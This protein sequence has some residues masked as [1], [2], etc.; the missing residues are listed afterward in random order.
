MALN[1]SNTACSLISTTLVKW[2]K[3]IGPNGI[4]KLLQATIATAACKNQLTPVSL[5]RVNVD[6]RYRARSEALKL[7][8]DI[9]D[10]MQLNLLNY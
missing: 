10:L 2:R 5:E 4:E 6:P 7:K 1:S 3:Q 8:T 9:D